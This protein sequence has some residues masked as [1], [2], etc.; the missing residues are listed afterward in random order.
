MKKLLTTLMA[1]AMITGTMALG[2]V[3]VS[4]AELQLHENAPYGQ[5]TSVGGECGFIDANLYFTTSLNVESLSDIKIEINGKTAY[6]NIGYLGNKHCQ[7]GNANDIEKSWIQLGIVG[8]DLHEGDDNTL[9]FTVGT[10]TYTQTFTSTITAKSYS[11]A[12]VTMDKVAKTVT[13]VIIYNDDPGYKV[14]DTFTGRCHDDHSTT[15]TFKVTEVDGKKVTLVAENYVTSQSL[16]E[17]KDENGVYTSVTINTAVSQTSEGTNALTDDQLATVLGSKKLT[18]SNPAVGGGFSS[19]TVGNAF[20]GNTGTAGENSGTKIEGG[21]V[22]GMTISWE[23]TEKA[24]YYVI[25]TGNDSKEWPRWP[26]AWTL[27]GS[28][29]GT[30]YVEIDKVVNSGM[31]AV[32]ATPFAY[33]IDTPDNYTSYKIEITEGSFQNNWFQINEIEMYASDA[34][35]TEPSIKVETVTTGE[36]AYTGT[37]PADP[38]TPPTT[39]KDDDDNDTPAPSTGDIAFLLSAV[40]LVAVAGAVVVAKKRKID[41]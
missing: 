2:A 21:F 28:K 36:G 4:A 14:G 30:D 35:I 41:D 38:V 29:N 5:F 9:K 18:L 39:D 3:S 25:Y 12:Q 27:Y 24:D 32:N 16:L 10:D 37:K 15:T 34:A 23:A 13:A 20:D 19:S 8:A 1:I 26:I 22:T 40:A 33:K 31:S 7:L 17:L 6:W 11:Y